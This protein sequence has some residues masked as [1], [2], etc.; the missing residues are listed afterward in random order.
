[1]QTNDHKIRD[2]STV[3]SAQYGEPVL[4]NELS[5]MKK[6]TLFTRVRLYLMPE[7]STAHSGG[8]CKNVSEQINPIFLE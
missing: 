4:L 2:Y 5:S 7:K 6:H 8:T 3:L 1:M